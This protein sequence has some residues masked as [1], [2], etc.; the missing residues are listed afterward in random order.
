MNILQLSKYYDPVN[1]GIELVAKQVTKAL[2][3][4]HHKVTV[5]AFS[6]NNS[7][8]TGKLGEEIIEV[9]ENLHFMSAPLSFLFFLKFKKLISEKK[10]D[11]IYV[12]LPN[13]F[14]HE[15]IS[16]HKGFLKKYNV[17][18]I[19]IYHSDILNKKFIGKLYQKYFL[20]FEGAYDSFISSSKNLQLTSPVLGE[21]KPDKVKVI[22]FCVEEINPFILR[23]NF[24]GKLLSIGRLVPYKGFE[25]LIDAVKGTNLQL[26]IVG[27]GP[28]FS[29]LN[30]NLPSNVKLLGDISDE[31]KNK[32][33][34]E[35]DI[36]VV[37]SNSRAEAFGMTIVE[38]FQAGLPV[39]AT[40]INTGVTFLVNHKHTGLTYPINDKKA[41]LEQF[42][43]LNSNKNLLGELS[44][45]CFNFYS[46]HL[47]FQYFQEKILGQLKNL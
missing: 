29:K 15:V 25:F 41:L 16:F 27:G 18:V 40:Q 7:V 11:V 35:S 30:E 2:V 20:A 12:H 42:E 21:V 26:T 31:Q 44:Q 6:K 34:L 43:E 4:A 19:G 45:G 46:S 10:I 14:M 1:G 17:K 24:K 23:S 32:L 33:L 5:V 22:P 38:A 39:L 9:K 47:K 13:P 36:L 3:Q 8:R 37:S 28:L